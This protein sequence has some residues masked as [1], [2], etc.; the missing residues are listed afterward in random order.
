MKVIN[1]LSFLFFS[2]TLGHSWA[3]DLS[4]N[5]YDKKLYS[6]EVQSHDINFLRQQTVG[7]LEQHVGKHKEKRFYISETGQ[8]IYK[9]YIPN[10][11]HIEYTKKSMEDIY[12][13][14][15]ILYLTPTGLKKHQV[16]FVQSTLY[17]V[18]NKPYQSTAVFKE[19]SGDGDMIVMDNLG[20]LFIHPKIRGLIHHSSFFS[21]SPLSFAGICYVE[22]GSIKNLLTYSGHYTPGEQEKKNW[23]TMLSV[24]ALKEAIYQKIRKNNHSYYEY[25]TGFCSDYGPSSNFSTY[26]DLGILCDLNYSSKKEAYSFRLLDIYQGNV[27]TES[28]LPS[29]YQAT[30]VRRA[31]NK[32]FV[33][34]KRGT[35][36]TI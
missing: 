35:K 23:S 13:D 30:K 3:V 16:F 21:G 11:S 2:F 5:D 17:N 27:L 19:S 1:F 33:L 7:F 26:E 20:N 6:Q 34:L 24:D 28:L 15:K 36:Y 10:V 9:L 8:E 12:S 25:N 31:Q 29:G 18:D 22:G 4:F 14:E 32:F